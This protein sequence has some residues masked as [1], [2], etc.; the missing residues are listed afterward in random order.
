MIIQ[1][2]VGL[3]VSNCSYIIN[4]L[5]IQAE[6]FSVKI[7]GC[8]LFLLPWLFVELYIHLIFFFYIV[9]CCLPLCGDKIVTKSS[10]TVCW[11]YCSIR[12]T[13]GFFLPFLKVNCTRSDLPKNVWTTLGSSVTSFIST[14][15]V[16]IPISEL[17]R[18]DPLS[19]EANASFTCDF[20]RFVQDCYYKGWW[21]MLLSYKP[22][23]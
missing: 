2:Y 10:S 7:W 22:I 3:P 14:F 21:I 9:H 13:A 23:Y 18:S 5:K 1:F 6:T 17:A 15:G 16:P 8:N 11:N 4:L 19:L 20:G 12:I